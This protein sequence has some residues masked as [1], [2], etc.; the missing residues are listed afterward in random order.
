[1]IKVNIIE[2]EKGFGQ[3]VIG[4][5]EFKSEEESDKFVVKYNSKNNKSSTPDYYTYAEVEN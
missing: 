3:K 1:M 5:K 2:S 4:S